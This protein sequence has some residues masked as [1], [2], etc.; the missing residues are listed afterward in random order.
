MRLIINGFDIELEPNVTIARTLQVNDIGS[1]ATRQASYTNTFSIPRTANNTRAMKMLGIIGNDSNV[2]YQKNECYLYSDSGESIVYKGWALITS[3]DKDFKCNVYDGIIDFYKAIENK[4]LADLDLSSLTHDKTV[5]NVLATFDLSKPYV[6]ILADYNGKAQHSNKINTDYLI[7]SLKVSWI[8]DRIEDFTGYNFIGEYKTSQDYLNLYLT[9]PKGTPP[10]LGTLIFNSADVVNG[11]NTITPTNSFIRMKA[12]TQ[13]VLTDLTLDANKTTFTSLKKMSV[14]ATVVVNPNITMVRQ[15]GST[16]NAYAT[17]GDEGFICDG[18][19][20]TIKVNYSL[21]IGSNFEIGMNVQFNTPFDTPPSSINDFYTSCTINKVESVSFETEFGG[22]QI[23]Q[24]INELLWKFNLTMF[25]DNFT[26]DYTL[27]T[28]AEIFETQSID[29]SSKF[30]S[31]DNEDYIYGS[32]GQRNWLRHKYNDENSFFNDGHLNV[33]NQNLPDSKTQIQSVTYS[34]DFIKSNN[35]GF[36]TNVYRFWNKEVKDNGVVEYKGLANRFY[37]MRLIIEEGTKDFT[38][39]ILS[40]NSSA[41]SCPIEAFTGLSFRE[42][43]DSYYQEMTAILNKSKVLTTT[44]RLNENDIAKFDFSK[45]V[46]LKQLGG[47]FLVNKINNFLP[48]KDTKVELLKIGE[49]TTQEQITSTI[50]AIEDTFTFTT[51]GTKTLDV[52]ANDNL[53][54]IPTNITAIN[55]LGGFSLGTLSITS[56]GQS[57]T[58]VSNG[59]NGTDTFTYTIIDSTGFSSQA[60]VTVTNDIPTFTIVPSTISISGG[61]TTTV[62]NTSST[63]I[64]VNVPT[65]NF[66]IG[67]R[68]L[69]G[70]G[71]A[72]G[73]LTING[74]TR[75][76]TNTSSS[77][78][79]S[80]PFTLTA[81]TYD[82]SLFKITLTPANVFAVAELRIEQIT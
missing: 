70:S 76:V 22:M 3:T 52:L 5:A 42:T 26:N 25:K 54:N 13:T 12:N 19:T 33:N 35:L 44:I 75:S 32:Y 49:V 57:I 60:T 6:Y 51:G 55:L 74:N 58:F 48:Y 30:Q 46:Y 7:P 15:N 82:S 2:P 63:Q 41:A 43:V 14:L 71:S 73:E 9:Y 78:V 28:L 59:N 39:E 37:F 69:T 45:P 65:L 50:N 64:I 56:G 17:I 4:T 29:W 27:K 72:T 47:S 20:R 10:V 79:F 36:T 38:S 53:G 81:G 40:L 8:M 23:K 18:T 80:A 61:G 77:F 62:N 21:D 31:L 1:V 16:Y 66:R 11:Q 24:F 67:V 68:V 34:P